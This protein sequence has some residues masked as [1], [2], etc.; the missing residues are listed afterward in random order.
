[1]KITSLMV[2]LTLTIVSAL[3]VRAADKTVEKSK[4]AQPL[5]APKTEKVPVSA[6]QKPPVEI[7]MT[8]SYL[9]QPIR[10]DGVVT[11]GANPVVVLSHKAIENSGAADLRELLVMRGIVR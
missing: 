1:M 10:R 3:T 8:G 9:K 11:D 2:A 6:A 7:A 5:H 4:S